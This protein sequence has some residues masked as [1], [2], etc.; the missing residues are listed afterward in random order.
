MDM[1]WVMELGLILGFIGV[2][3]LAIP[4]FKSKLT[5]TFEYNPERID[6]NSTR[7]GLILIGFGF[8]AQFVAVWYTP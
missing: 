7:T 4:S 5:N 6:V 8:V 1:K 3:I 2:G